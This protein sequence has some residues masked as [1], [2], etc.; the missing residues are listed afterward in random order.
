VKNK[1]K[2]KIKNASKAL[3][4]P[5]SHII[6]SKHKLARKKSKATF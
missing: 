1:K 6:T 2:K 5:L 3:Q 4:T